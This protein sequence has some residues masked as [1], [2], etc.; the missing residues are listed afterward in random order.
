MRAHS[1]KLVQLRRKRRVL[2]DARRLSQVA[3]SPAEAVELLAR[4]DASP[5]ELRVAVDNPQ[6]L[7]MALDV[8][9]R[10][11][12]PELDSAENML[13]NSLRTESAA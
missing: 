10:Q 11:I 1:A 2:Q 6:V 5:E 9:A 3:H 12:L 8:L 7:L 4:L 13:R